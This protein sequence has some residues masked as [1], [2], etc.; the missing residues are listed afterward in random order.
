MP[1]TLVL[2]E[3]DVCGDFYDFSPIEGM[4]KRSR[5]WA[6][7]IPLKSPVTS[8]VDVPGCLSSSGDRIDTESA[9]QLIEP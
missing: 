9:R 1:I 2:R 7:G 4:P 3:V 8:M 6:E 5:Q